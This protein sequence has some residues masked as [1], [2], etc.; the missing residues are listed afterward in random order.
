MGVDLH[1][2]IVHLSLKAFLLA[3]KVL[4]GFQGHTNLGEL[5]NDLEV[6]EEVE[7]SARVCCGRD[8][9]EEL[10]LLL[11]HIH[12]DFLCNPVDPLLIVV[13]GGTVLDFV[14]EGFSVFKDVC[15]FILIRGILILGNKFADQVEDFERG[16]IS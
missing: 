10:A 14:S 3:L 9:P 13:G 6:G 7:E 15:A 12:V 11:L 2:G 5:E 8:F 1:L 16:L 4:L